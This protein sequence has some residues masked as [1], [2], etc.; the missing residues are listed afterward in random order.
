MQQK[1]KNILIKAPEYL[2]YL[3]VFLLPWQTRWIARDTI[4]NS[5]VWE[6][7][8]IGVYGF[9][10]V[11]IFL[12]FLIGLGHFDASH[13]KVPVLDLSKKFLIFNFKFSNNF[14]FLNFKIGKSYLIL[15]GVIFIA[16][17]IFVAA[18]KILAIYWWLRIMEGVGLIWLIK[19]IDY[20]KIRLAAAFVLSM[21]F[22]AGL[23]IYQ[24]INA[25]SGAT[26]W[27]GLAWRKAENLGDSVVEA[28]GERFLRAYGSL[29]HPNILAGFL[30]VALVLWFCIFLQTKNTNSKKQ[31]IFLSVAGVFLTSGLFFT[32]SRAAWLA[33]IMVCAVSGMVWI[34]QKSFE[35][36]KKI[37][38]A[39]VILT[40][41]ILAGVYWPLVAVRTSNKTRLE[42]KSTNE[43]VSGYREAL[44]IIE[45]QS[46]W[47]VG[48]GNYTKVLAQKN[49]SSAAW[50]NQPVHNVF[51]LAWAE[52]GMVGILLWGFLLYI[53]WKGRDDLEMKKKW[54]TWGLLGSV[55]VFLGVF[56]HYLWTLPA[57]MLLVFA[58]F[59][60]VLKK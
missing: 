11:F 52:L 59:G 24:F 22:S 20:A 3:F 31:N 51:V 5:A 8:R 44:K 56:D 47:G 4:V 50:N 17:N 48:L 42:I 23:G 57:G 18:D 14:K 2:L 46:V 53:L 39:S 33:G 13:N 54:I 15:L 29:P 36:Y 21:L 55:F 27:L 38:L 32:F 34:K 28:N 1:I 43:R 41:I 6:Y 10:V 25:G 30:V 16:I 37:G 26:K 19:K 40:A 35:Q 49:P 58:Y 9:D 60:S 12:V 45:E 7:G